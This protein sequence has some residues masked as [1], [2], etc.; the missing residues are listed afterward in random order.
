MGSDV[1]SNLCD[2]DPLPDS[3]LTKVDEAY[4]IFCDTQ[5]NYAIIGVKQQ[6]E[7]KYQDLAKKKCKEHGVSEK[8][9]FHSSIFVYCSEDS[10]T[11]YCVEFGKL[12]KCKDTY[13]YKDFKRFYYHKEKESKGGV[14]FNRMKKEDYT[15]HK[16]KEG[17]I[18]L[19]TNNCIGKTFMEKAEQNYIFDVKNYHPYSCNCHIFV[20][21]AVNALSA[22]IIRGSNNKCI[23]NFPDEIINLIQ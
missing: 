19:K 11:G 22:K 16:C 6:I 15:F 14:R 20:R 7:K 1:C 5:I 3:K 18:Y 9:G 8:Y 13:Y 17:L 4:E 23:N 10:L 12:K 21:E 2:D